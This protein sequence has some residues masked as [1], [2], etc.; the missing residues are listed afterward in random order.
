[1]KTNEAILLFIFSFIIEI[2]FYLYLQM[3]L[4]IWEQ[5]SLPSWRWYPIRRYQV[6]AETRHWTSSPKTSLVG[7]RKTETTPGPFSLL[8]TVSQASPYEI[9]WIS[10]GSSG[11]IMRCMSLF[12][13][14]EEDPEGLRSGSRAAGS[15]PSD[16]EHTADRQ[17]ASQQTL[18]RP[19]VRPGESQL[20][21][22]LRWIHQVCV[23]MW[24]KFWTS[25]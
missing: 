6:M 16:R 17:R 25:G 4:K 13:R 21:G 20:Q 12:A 11:F 3:H 14:S 15:A 7:T 2:Y 24:A 18:R 10:G 22:D 1:M 23:K 5:F 8:I 9:L 19:E